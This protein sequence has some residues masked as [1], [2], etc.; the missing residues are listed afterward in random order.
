MRIVSG[1]LKG[2]HLSTPADEQIRPTAEKVREALF[3][4]LA[5]EIID[6]RFIDL[7]AGTGAVG[8]EALSR[9]A[10]W[11]D[12]VERDKDACRLIAKNLEGLGLL[13]RAAVHWVDAFK[14]IRLRSAAGETADIV[15]ADPPYLGPALPRLLPRL[16]H[17]GM[18]RP[19]G[20][21]VVE[22]FHKNPLPETSGILLRTD[23]RRYGDATL[24]FYRRTQSGPGEKTGD[25]AKGPEWTK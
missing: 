22:H 6:T 21:L 8:L 5:P 17:G 20:L 12:F 2:R 3:Q 11:V 25:E 18:I 14:F 9:G 10:R 4:I 16:G 7:F 13:G 23:M 15:Y 19:G 24:T 1:K